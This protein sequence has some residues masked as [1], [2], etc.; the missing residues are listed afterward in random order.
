M[1]AAGRLGIPIDTSGG[2]F[3][4]SSWTDQGNRPLKALP[5]RILEELEL[6]HSAATAP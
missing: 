1:L 6:R 2:H 5:T 3:C 4:A